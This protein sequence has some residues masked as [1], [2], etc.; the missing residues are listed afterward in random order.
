M[1]IS[2][3]LCENEERERIIMSDNTIDLD[4]EW[5]KKRYAGLREDVESLKHELANEKFL[6]NQIS[7]K[8]SRIN[9]SSTCH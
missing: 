3:N 2:Y 6:A 1:G 8:I 9:K 7:E 4:I 5:Y